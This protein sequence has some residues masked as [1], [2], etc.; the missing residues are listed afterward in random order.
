MR[1]KA[2]TDYLGDDGEYWIVVDVDELPGDET[3]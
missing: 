3:N 1:L 2:E